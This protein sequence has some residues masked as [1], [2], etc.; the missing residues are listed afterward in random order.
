T[1]DEKSN[2]G[3]YDE[4][5]SARRNAE[6]NRP[7]AL[8]MS[9]LRTPSSQLCEDGFTSC[10]GG[11]STTNNGPR[12]SMTSNDVEPSRARSNRIDAVALPT[13]TLRRVTLGSHSGSRGRTNA[14]T[15][16]GANG[17][18]PSIVCTSCTTAL[19]LHACGEFDLG[20]AVGIGVSS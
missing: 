5:L 19:A 2:I 10:G 12:L 18:R 8:S 3:A 6:A 7:G 20:Y 17:Y 15:C 4:M 11:I 1:H 13:R 16:A 9:Q 14:S